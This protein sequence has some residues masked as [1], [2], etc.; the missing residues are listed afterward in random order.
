[1]PLLFLLCGALC[2]LPCPPA[3]FDFL[4]RHTAIPRFYWLVVLLLVLCLSMLLW[5]GPLAVCNF[6]CFVYPAYKTYQTLEGKGLLGSASSSSAAT[7][8]TTPGGPSAE[9]IVDQEEDQSIEAHQHWL[10][11]WCVYGLFKLFEFG[12]DLLCMYWIPSYWSG[13]KVLFL[14]W[15]FHPTTQGCSLVYTWVIRPLFLPREDA[16]DRAIDQF[17][18]SVNQAF[19]E[20]KGIILKKVA[21]RIAGTDETPVKPDKE[22]R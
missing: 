19:V 9:T 1:M 17:N 4:E 13:L 2:F 6:I 22:R 12:P 3:I 7:S 20:V 14:V 8:T 18:A 16:I 15:C 21:R 5:I 10:S 11:Y